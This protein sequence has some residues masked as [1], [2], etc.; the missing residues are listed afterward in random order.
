MSLQ[1]KSSSN[2]YSKIIL[3]CTALYFIFWI[4]TV[5]FHKLPTFPVIPKDSS[6]YA[7]L[8]DSII[9]SG[10]FT[11]D[12]MTNTFRT[13]GYPVFLAIVKEIF[14]GSYFAVTFIQILLALFSAFLIMKIGSILYDEK[15]AGLAAIFFIINPITLTLSLTIMS[16]MLFLFL[17]LLFFWVC[18]DTIKERFWFGII[19]SGIICALALYV[20]PMGL[21]A[22][23]IFA[24]PVLLSKI[25]IQ[26]KL[27]AM[28]F[29]LLI[30]ILMLI[31]WMIRNKNVSGVFAFTSLP[32][33]NI[34]YY[35]A[36]MFLAVK[37]KTS[38]PIERQEISSQIN[39][40]VEQWDELQYS[41]SIEKYTS[42]FFKTNI[43]SY[44]KYHLLTTSAFFFSSDTEYLIDNYK[45]MMNENDSANL[46]A[47]DT[48]ARG[49]ISSF[50]Y[51]ITHP[52][53]KFIERII[54][55]LIWIMVFA[56][57]YTHRKRPLGYYLLFIVIFL[58]LLAGPV[59]NA[60]YRFIA[61]PFI[62]LLASA[63]IFSLFGERIKKLF[64]KQI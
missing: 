16:D 38:A 27:Y 41:P 10:T 5:F 54:I 20:R 26:K 4:Y 7:S 35:N 32:Y 13:P 53:W 31:P 45:L 62:M 40:P 2:I 44:A 22:L 56:E 19:T 47:I 48:L 37:N 34:V 39:V 9:N 42:Q 55:I 29:I 58:A 63:G 24:V 8:S 36:P 30:T 14:F 1:P 33:Y 64:C 25:N 15:I 17:F 50:L 11:I 51:S 60:R 52:I 3:V 61:E 12:G 59:A 43:F 6:E 23:P 49:N 57:I 21:F 46:G 28:F 18:L